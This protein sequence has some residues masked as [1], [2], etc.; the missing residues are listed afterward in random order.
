MVVYAVIGVVSNEEY[1]RELCYGL[2]QEQE[3]AHK[4]AYELNE[5]LEEIKILKHSE[6]AKEQLTK[7]QVANDIEMSKR[8]C[9]DDTIGNYHGGENIAKWT[10]REI[11]VAG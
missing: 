8:F 4:Q 1:N 10:V 2:F 3:A 11:S 7:L 6:E 9:S 5:K